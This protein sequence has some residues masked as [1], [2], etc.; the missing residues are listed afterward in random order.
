MKPLIQKLGTVDA[1]LVETTPVV[2]KD[3]L[4]RF[5]Y[6]RERYW[7]N[8]TGDSYF[9]FVNH[10]TGQPGKP[11]AQGYHLGNVLATE[12]TLYV[13]GTNAWDGERVDIFTSTDME[14]WTVSNALNLPGYGLFNTSLCC[15]PDGYVLM[16]EIGRPPEIAGSRYTAL[17][18]K[19]PD[20][21]QWTVMPLECTYAKD[22]YTA[23][24]CLRYHDGYYYNFYLEALESG[25]EQYVVRSKDLINWES[26]PL[27]PVLRADDEDRKIANPAISAEQREKIKTAENCNNSDID[28][29]EYQG[30]LVI[31]YS[32][33]NQQG[34]EYLAEARF[35]GTLAEFLTGWFPNE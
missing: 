16:F 22:R 15:D 33:G 27:N 28:L 31:N 8:D 32:W 29:C 5:E 10:D 23:P 17:F 12:D 6:V 7:G 25:L 34:I 26:S 9:R 18:A 30:H 35:D 24:H 20:M 13:T 2:F 21:K 3:T 14:N 19:S 11:F 1:D 4:Y